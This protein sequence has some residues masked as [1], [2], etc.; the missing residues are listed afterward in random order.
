[1]QQLHGDPLLSLLGSPSA[2]FT[3]LDRPGDK[4]E[5]RGKNTFLNKPGAK[6]TVSALVP[7]DTVN[8][9]EA[10]HPMAARKKP[11]K[12]AKKC[13]T[14]PESPARHRHFLHSIPTR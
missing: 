5:D 8:L 6:A 11:R 12:T 10:A 2:S 13:V 9:P 7:K 4:P 14:P 3:L 1:M